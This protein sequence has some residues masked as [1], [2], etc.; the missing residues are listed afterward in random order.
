M[1]SHQ[2]LKHELK[3]VAGAMAFFGAWIG[4]L[5]LMKTLVLAEYHVGFSGWSKIL[6]G[7][8]IL[9]KVLLVLEHVSL[10]TWLKTQPAWV[11]V[12]MRTAFYALGVFVV[13]LLEKGFEG[14]HAHGGFGRSLVAEFQHVNENHV[15]VNTLCLT[16]ALLCYNAVSVIRQ[17]L[18][19]GG[20]RR[21][22]LSPL[23]EATASDP[24][25]RGNRST[26]NPD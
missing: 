26:G 14:R 4:A 13:L 6:V 24:R 12:L 8:S 9:S 19:R 20:L 16:G 5:I 22:F 23:P 17:H 11:H 18:G 2:K 10:G 1:G 7:A 3:A 15:L 25:D 21:L